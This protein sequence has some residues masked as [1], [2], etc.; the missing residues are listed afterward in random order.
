MRRKVFLGIVLAGLVM[1]LTGGTAAEGPEG[2]FSGWTK[3][4]LA[5][6]EVRIQGPDGRFERLRFAREGVTVP[7]GGG[8]TIEIT[9]LD[10]EGRE[11]PP[12]RTSLEVVPDRDARD[13]VMVRDEG[14]GRFRITARDRRG[15]GRI[16]VR[17]AN[18]LNLEW[19]VP[20]RVEGPGA[21]GYSRAEAEFIA[22]ALYRALLGRGPDREG[23]EAATAEI[24]RGRLKAQVR[25]MLT[26]AEFRQ[27]ASG[28]SAVALLDRLY[29]GLLGRTPDAD[30][31]RQYLADLERHRV[32]KVVLS[33]LHSDEFARR[34]VRATRGRRAHTMPQL[35]VR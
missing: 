20:L 27:K 32:E 11:F 34:L 23:L 24:E 33:I 12:D 2:P 13:L 28:L 30:G 17:A 14:R 21:D 5:G 18:N 10:Q 3:P 9:G 1:G 29:R 19:P 7:M 16:L 15:K 8:V 35:K 31:T 26:S 25:G 4:V 6:I 22:T